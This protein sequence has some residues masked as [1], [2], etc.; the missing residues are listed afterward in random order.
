M[1]IVLISVS[2]VVVNAQSTIF[3]KYNEVRNV[4][5]VFISKTMLEMQPNLYTKDVYIGKVAGQLDAV[6][7]ISTMDNGVKNNM[8]KDLE[9]FVKKSKYEMLMK[10]KGLTSSS[11]FYIKKKGDKVREL[12]MIID[13][14]AKLS[15]VQLV[16]DLTLKDIQQ[17]TNHHHQSRNVKIIMPDLTPYFEGSAKMNIA[18]KQIMKEWKNLDK[19]VNPDKLREIKEQIQKDLKNVIGSIDLED[20]NVYN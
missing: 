4:S 16:G 1:W 8:R 17:I 7:I 5:S 18:S 2:P 10:Q 12:V 15:F 9:D 20:I 3:D 14:A 19:Y 11:S 13:G 6:Y